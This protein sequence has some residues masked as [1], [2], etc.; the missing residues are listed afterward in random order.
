VQGGLEM[1][2][3]NMDIMK[4]H[5]KTATGTYDGDLE[6]ELKINAD[7]LSESYT[8]Q[9]PK[10]A[11]WAVLAEQAR[12]IVNNLENQIKDKETYL[13][14]VLPKELGVKIRKEYKFQTLSDKE[15]VSKIMTHPEYT[16]NL[17]QLYTL[18]SKYVS[19]LPKVTS[20]SL[21]SW[22]MPAARR[23]RAH[24]N[25]SRPQSRNHG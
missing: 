13:S 2:N 4:I 15:L 16:E 21:T 12:S 7:N 19:N 20:R 17:Q 9:A 11:W 25:V 1:N 6:K 22:V 3:K 8:D 24:I 10:Y 14:E 5:V 18:R 23:P